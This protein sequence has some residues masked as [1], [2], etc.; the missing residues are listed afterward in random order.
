MQRLSGLFL[1]ACALLSFNFSAAA[2]VVVYPREAKAG[3]YEV[4]TVRCPNEKDTPTM[5]LELDIPA[6]E[7]AI[8]NYEPVPGWKAELEMDTSG[9]ATKITWTTEG[10]GL[11]PHQF[12]EFKIMGKIDSE[13]KSITWKA[14]QTY[15]GSNGVVDWTGEAGSKSPASVTKL[16]SGDKAAMAGQA[17]N[18]AQSKMAFNL[19]LAALIVGV[20]AALVA[21]MRK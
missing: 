10:E 16:S 8:H 21:F 15:T 5:K 7:I 17:G 19:A 13:A 20:I 11:L 12:G 9:N 4:F 3:S 18:S 14:H 1:A 6:S 2:H